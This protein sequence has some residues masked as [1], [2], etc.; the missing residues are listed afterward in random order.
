MVE[1]EAPVTMETR[2][3]K[4][5]E[6]RGCEAVAG[7]G[8]SLRACVSVLHHPAPPHSE[9]IRLSRLCVHVPPKKIP[10]RGE[11]HIVTLINLPRIV[12]HMHFTDPYVNSRLSPTTVVDTPL[13]QTTPKQQHLFGS[14]RGTHDI[15]YMYMSLLLLCAA[16]S[17]TDAATVYTKRFS[18]VPTTEGLGR[19]AAPATAPAHIAASQVP[20]DSAGLRAYAFGLVGAAGV[21]MDLT[22]VWAR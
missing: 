21:P 2:E 14:L 12:V 20:D 22:D 11:F 19:A 5:R 10:F 8:G 16:S 1:G 18:S 3:T 15:Y 9:A 6:Y 13:P 17:F 7:A 4:T